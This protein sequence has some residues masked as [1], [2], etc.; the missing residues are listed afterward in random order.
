MAVLHGP[1]RY[2]C[3]DHAPRVEDGKLEIPH[4]VQVG[5]GPDGTRRMM[6]HTMSWLP[7][8]CGHDQ[9]DEDPRC[10]GC[11]WRKTGGEE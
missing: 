8:E 9:S 5:R 1:G 11:R 10:D 3:H 6:W 4:L 2:A 7:I